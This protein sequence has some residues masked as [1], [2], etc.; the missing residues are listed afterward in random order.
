MNLSRRTVL[1]GAAATAAAVTLGSQIGIPKSEAAAAFIKGADISWAPQMEANGYYWLN[2][3]GVRQDLLTIL[4]SYGITAIR[5]RMFVNPSAD[6]WSGHCSTEETAQLALRVKNAGMQVMLSLMFGDTWNSVGTQKPPAAWA[7]MTYPQMLEAMSQYVYHAMNVI[8]YYKVAPA[9]V[10][11]GNEE[12]SGICHPTGSVSRPA[13]MTGLLMAAYNQVKY[14][15]PSTKILVHCGQPQ[16]LDSVQNFLTKY[17]DNGGLWDITGL[18]SYAQGS[19]VPGLLSAMKTLQDTYGKPVMQVEYGGPLA[20]PT[21]VRD[22]LSA[23]V[24][25]LKSFG[26][27]ARSSGSR[28]A[29][30]SSRRDT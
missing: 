14:V 26:A 2:K 10:T 30:R 29:T 9:W 20:K 22:S 13:Q 3:S 18:S 7:S 23:F 27:S 28:K 8:K 19:N 21:Q 12:N 5:L 17:R 1:S 24:T 11:I 15:F 4:K 16:K 25:G 6:E